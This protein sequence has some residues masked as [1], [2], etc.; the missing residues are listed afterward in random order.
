[1][2]QNSLM[3]LAHL[4]LLIAALVFAVSAIITFA[5]TKT[6]DAIVIGCALVTFAIYLSV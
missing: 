2:D 1:M 5:R 6:V 4:C 3:D